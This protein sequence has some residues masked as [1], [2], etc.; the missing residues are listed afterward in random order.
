MVGD[1]IFESYD[2]LAG[3]I[4]GSIMGTSGMVTLQL[5]CRCSIFSDGLQHHI[6]YILLFGTNHIV[7]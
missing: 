1:M 3:Q 4:V 7:S 5:G 2:T 6:L